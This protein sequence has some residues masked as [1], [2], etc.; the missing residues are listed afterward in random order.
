MP[1]K[2]VG[3]FLN[4]IEEAD[5]RF[6]TRRQIEERGGTVDRAIDMEEWHDHFRRKRREL[7]DFLERAIRLRE[8]ICCEL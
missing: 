8:P 3:R 2:N 4:M 1:V 5:Q 6:P 7:I